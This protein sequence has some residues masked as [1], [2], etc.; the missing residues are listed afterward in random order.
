MHR[1]HPNQPA[2]PHSNPSPTNPQ[3]QPHPIPNPNPTSTATSSRTDTRPHPMS[4]VH[5]S[6]RD[7]LLPSV[8]A[9]ADPSSSSFSRSPPVQRS[10]I[11]M[12]ILH[13]RSTCTVPSPTP[14]AMGC[15]AWKPQAASRLLSKLLP[16]QPTPLAH[17]A[18]CPAP[19]PHAAVATVNCRWRVCWKAASVDRMAGECLLRC[20]RS[21]SKLRR[22]L[23]TK[24]H[25]LAPQRDDAVAGG[26][27]RNVAMRR[28]APPECQ[29]VRLG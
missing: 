26:E 9:A 7:P 18:P 8:D 5:A 11:A 2:Q 1:L 15:T 22:S 14:L 13:C 10:A 19:A 25:A 12:D 17:A 29:E 3:P 6:C 16:P 27:G 21:C 24:A 23:P 28:S 20:L 4:R